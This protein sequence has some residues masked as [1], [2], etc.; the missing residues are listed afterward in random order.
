[1]NCLGV[2]VDNVVYTLRGEVCF[3][4]STDKR[5]QVQGGNLKTSFRLGIS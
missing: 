5:I 1:M 4:V 2:E 3:Q